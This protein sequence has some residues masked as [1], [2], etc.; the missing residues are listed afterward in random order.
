MTDQPASPED[1]PDRP[2]D[3]EHSGPED[4][5]KRKFREALDRRR[6]SKADASSGR[7]TDPSKIH[8]THG[9]SGG[10]RN[11]RRKSG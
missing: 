11:F 5:L 3:A 1:G 10:A 8:G 9:K 2:A 4:D 6:D 7:G